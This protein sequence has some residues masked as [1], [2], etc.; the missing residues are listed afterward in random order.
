MTSS[1]A[2]SSFIVGSQAIEID[3][4]AHAFRGII[5]LYLLHNMGHGHALCRSGIRPSSGIR[6]SRLTC[7]GPSA[8]RPLSGTRMGYQDP[9]NFAFNRWY[10][11]RF[12]PRFRDGKV[13]AEEGSEEQKQ[14][15]FILGVFLPHFLIF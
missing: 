14:V 7:Q 2:T 8:P 1:C 5:R 11:G 10:S 13:G 6:V 3:R 15:K 12:I 9:R 4:S